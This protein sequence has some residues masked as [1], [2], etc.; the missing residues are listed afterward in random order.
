VGDKWGVTSAT[1]RNRIKKLK[2]LGV[3]DVMTVINPYKVGYDNFALIRI[4]IKVDAHPEKFVNT[5]QSIEGIT[6]ITMV[7]GSFDFFVTCVCRNLEEYRRFFTETLRY[8]SEIA[9]VESFIGLDI[10][11]RNILVGVVR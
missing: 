2:T 5:L 3:I 4:K 11:E 6:G 1:V 8:L 10:Y 7:T 9:S